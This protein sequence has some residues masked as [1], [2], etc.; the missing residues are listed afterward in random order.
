MGGR[1]IRLHAIRVRYGKVHATNWLWS[2]F[3]DCLPL[4]AAR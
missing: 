3:L 1:R 4:L 2:Q